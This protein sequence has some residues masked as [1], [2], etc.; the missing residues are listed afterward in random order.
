MYEQIDVL[1]ENGIKTGE[2]MARKEFIN[3]DCGTVLLLWQL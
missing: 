3:K 2:V 1:N